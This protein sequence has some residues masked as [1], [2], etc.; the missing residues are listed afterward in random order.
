MCYAVLQCLH[1]SK[2]RARNSGVTLIIQLLI[3]QLDSIS[4]LL[5]A[6]VQ[7]RARNCCLFIVH[8]SNLDSTYSALRTVCFVEQNYCCELATIDVGNGTDIQY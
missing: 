7:L 4:L 5:C 8:S 1:H 6:Y 2:L 3:N